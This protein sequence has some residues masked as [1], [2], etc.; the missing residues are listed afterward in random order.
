MYKELSL[1]A[2]NEALREQLTSKEQNQYIVK[3]EEACQKLL[4]TLATKSYTNGGRVDF[5]DK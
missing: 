1:N 5:Y 3:V 2:R 4:N